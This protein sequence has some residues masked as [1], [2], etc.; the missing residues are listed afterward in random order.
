MTSHDQS[1]P[2]ESTP[3]ASPPSLADRIRGAIWGQFVGHVAW[4]D[5]LTARDVIGGD[6]E[7][8]I[9][10]VADPSEQKAPGPPSSYCGQ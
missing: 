2:A 6:V 5:R 10:R 3:A 1:L 9:G 7:I 4:R 8:I